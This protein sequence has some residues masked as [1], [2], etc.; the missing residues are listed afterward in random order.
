M[1]E[2]IDRGT[3]PDVPNNDGLTTAVDGFAYA[4][5]STSP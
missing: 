2:M 3:T 5:A 4:A 1:I